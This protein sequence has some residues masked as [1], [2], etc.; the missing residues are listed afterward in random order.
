MRIDRL[1]AVLR[2]RSPWEGI[3][4]GL[5][6]AR[7]WF[8]SLFGLWW[9]TALPLGALSA[10]WL[11]SMPSLWMLVIWWGKPL[12]EAPL[13]FWMS[14]RLF[15]ERLGPRALWRARRQ[16]FPFRLLP[17]LLWR[18]FDPRRSLHLPVLLLEGLSG[19]ARRQRQRLLQSP[20]GTAAWLTFIMIHLESILWISALLLTAYMIPDELP[21]LDL[22]ASLFE[23]GSLPYWISTL[24]YWLAMAMLAPFYVAAGFALYLSRRM[25]LEAWDL[26]L[27][28]RRLEDPPDPRRG[29]TSSLV[30]TAALAVALSGQ[31]DPA[32]A[33]E[34]SPAQA[35]E[36]IAAVLE[37]EDFHR[38]YYQETW[39]FVEPDTAY[40]DDGERPDWMIEWLRLFDRL[41]NWAA[42][43]VQGLLGLGSALLGL[44]LLQRLPREWR[45]RR[46][47]GSETASFREDPEISWLPETA[48]PADVAAVVEDLLARGEVRGA[49]AQLYAASLALLHRRHGLSFRDSATEG[50]CLARILETRP[51][52][53]S[54]LMRRLIGLWRQLAYGHREPAS[55][56]LAALVADWR[57][58]EAGDHGD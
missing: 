16:I 36:E 52:V 8:P 41:G 40:G 45:G 49:L 26:E 25:E 44:W 5:A 17:L 46:R 11:A 23:T 28:F 7:H 32:F 58:W 42:L 55:G 57:R 1:A 29:Q 33:L 21:A 34:L 6:L 51:P 14:R 30:V 50:E 10:F 22:G 43:G 19:K 27:Q 47:R 13:L 24:W 18:R 12:Y 20:G 56:E 48:L 31:A 3:D 54:A 37:G 39:V 2:P 4:L 35:R 53:E 38:K 15:G 9:L